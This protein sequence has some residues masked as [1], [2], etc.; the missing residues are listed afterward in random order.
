MISLKGL[1][2]AQR[3]HTGN[4]RRLKRIRPVPP[5]H[6]VELWYKV[7]LLSIVKQL[8]AATN[9][10][11]LPILKETAPQ[12]QRVKDG[13]ITDAYADRIASGINAMS[14]KFGGIQD[15]ANRL[16]ELV[17][18]KASEEADEKLITSIRAAV[19]V[20]TTAMLTSSAISD[21]IAIATRANIEL[22]KTIPSQYF[23]KIQS[24]VYTNTSQGMRFEDLADKIQEI[25][26]VTESRAKLIARDQTSKINSSINE[27]RQSSLG[28][29]KYIWRTS[30]DER[31]RETH[32]AN[33]G[34]IFSWDEPPA[35]TG[36][37]GEDINCR[38]TAEAYID[39]DEEEANAGP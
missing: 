8:R 23:D 37:P 12:Y 38:C 20:D 39:F 22:I 32:A 10:I 5:S 11:L 3:Q 13:L 35:E 27:A 30:G 24:A 4:K 9:E 7:Q 25:G 19:G 6:K 28:I 16:A 29:K 18:R 1:I 21:Q 17:V 31:V 36:H 33:E 26:D 34:Q 15:T 14:K 2:A